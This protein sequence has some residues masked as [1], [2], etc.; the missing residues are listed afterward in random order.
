[1]AHLKYAFKTFTSLTLRQT[2]KEF[3]QTNLKT[4]FETNSIFSTAIHQLYQ[5]FLTFADE[6]PFLKIYF[7]PQTYNYCLDKI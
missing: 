3:S 6:G 4:R 7:L 1:M 2:V 5:W